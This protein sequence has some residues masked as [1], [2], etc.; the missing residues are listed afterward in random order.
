MPS[1]IKKNLWRLCNNALPVSETLWK[2]IMVKNLVF[3]LC[4]IENESVEHTVSLYKWTR[5]FWFW[6]K[7]P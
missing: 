7:N 3:L 2:R 5:G 1:K 4:S 6:N